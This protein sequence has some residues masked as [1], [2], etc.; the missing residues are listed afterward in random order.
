MGE[1]V[2][3]HRFELDGRRFAIDPETCFCFECDA[4]SWDVLEHYPHETAQ[5]IYHLLGDRHDL[6]ELSEVLGELEWLRASKSIL[7][8]YTQEELQKHF[9][10][11]SGLKRVTVRL[12]RESGASSP[13]RRGWFVRG[14]AQPAPGIAGRVQE[15]VTLLLGRSQKQQDLHLEFIEERSRFNPEALAGFCVSAMQSASL[16][17]KNLTVSFR[18]DGVSLDGMGG[19]LHGHNVSA[20]IEFR[21]SADAARSLAAFAKALESRSPERLAK[22]MQPGGEHISGRLIVQPGHPAFGGV[23]AALHQAGFTLIELDLDGSFVVH[24]ELAPDAMLPAMTETAVAYAQTLLKGAYFRLDPIATLFWRIYSGLPMRRTDPIGTNE[25]VIDEDGAVYPSRHFVGLSPFRC[26]SVA[27]GRLDN[28]RIKPYEDVGALTTAP[29]IDCWARHLCGGGTAAVH[30]ALTG[31]FRTPHEAWCDAHR[32]WLASAVSA[33]NM[34]S[35]AG[36]SFTNLYHRLGR[37]PR[38]SL[39]AMARAA[40]RPGI[41]VRPIEES[42]AD[43]LVKWENWN[44]ATYFTYSIGGAL[45]TTKYDREMDAAHPSLDVQE[46]VLTKTDGTAF[47]LVRLQPEMLDGVVRA[48]VYLRHEAD[49]ADESIRKGFRGLLKEALGHQSLRRA[50]APAG[51]HDASLR[52]FLEGSG[53]TRIG[54]EREGLYLHGR[55]LDVWHYEAVSDEL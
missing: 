16:A 12:P 32:A 29:C 23:A 28:D 47:G 49:Y 14:A 36:V 40:F 7:P 50:L 33:F 11:D 9:E 17:G 15:A 53:F 48:R 3:I 21:E 44:E 41:G 4:V 39:F 42:D 22:A 34:L 24:P 45:L 20:A 13:A 2:A 54:V 37:L 35:S 19:V 18:V 6:K 10:I 52:S 55:Y 51:A 8:A 30:H 46:M 43:W 27:E 5:R 1:R 31:S 26:G 25:L 38:P